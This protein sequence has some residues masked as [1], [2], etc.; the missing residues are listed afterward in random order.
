MGIEYFFNLK[1]NESR[2]FN[3]LNVP[4]YLES[5][6]VTSIGYECELSVCGDPCTG[7]SFCNATDHY[8][9]FNYCE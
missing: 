8:Y 3:N 6:P 4:I 5:C 9:G 1:L 2:F 7:G